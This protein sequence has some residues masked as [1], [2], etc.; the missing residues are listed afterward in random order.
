MRSRISR[1]NKILLLDSF[2]FR[3]LRI[4]PG[5][6]SYQERKGKLNSDLRSVQQREVGICARR[7]W[8]NRRGRRR[9]SR[10]CRKKE[11][12]KTK[13][14][15]GRSRRCNSV[16]VGDNTGCF[17]PHGPREKAA[18]LQVASGLASFELFPLMWRRTS[19]P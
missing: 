6:R 11:G 19:R 12:A 7:G 1:K 2:R 9:E 13:Y 18:K 14:E 17:C 8:R 5:G 3:Q 10:G 15:I 16:R 4:C